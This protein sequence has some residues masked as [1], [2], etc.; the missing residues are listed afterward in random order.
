MNLVIEDF[1]NMRYHPF[2]FCTEGEQMFVMDC[3][4][5]I[6][7]KFKINLIVHIGVDTN[8]F[9]KKNFEMDQG[10]LDKLIMKY[11][12]NLVEGEVL[13]SHWTRD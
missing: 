6:N 5:K 8:D 10:I 2:I 3:I 11:N 7:K 4:N 12:S 9:T 1:A 13:L